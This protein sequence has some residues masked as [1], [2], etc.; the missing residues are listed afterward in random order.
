MAVDI[1]QL[2]LID[3]DPILELDPTIS[4][5]ISSR[6]EAEMAVRGWTEADMT[7]QRAVLLSLL[8]TRSL[9]TRLLL[10]FSQEIKKTT[11]GKATVEFD[12]AIKYLEEL[13]SDLDFRISRTEK[14]VAPDQIPSEVRWTSV[15]LVGF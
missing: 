9:V 8:V 6:I 11:A 14:S 10:R 2:V 1:E 12:N 7:D 4:Q 15:G 3:L 5:T 13:R